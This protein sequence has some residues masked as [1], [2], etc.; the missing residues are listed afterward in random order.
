MARPIRPTTTR[1]RGS[2]GQFGSSRGWFTSSTLYEGIGQFRIKN[3]R[4]MEDIAQEFARDLVAYAQLNA[5]WN[6]RTGDARAGLSTEVEVAIRDEILVS[7]FHTVDYGIWL[8][9]RWG[10]K[11]AII[12]PTIEAMGPRLL[13]RMQH[14]MDRIIYY[15]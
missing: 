13:L 10:G 11:Y 1:I 6:D 4:K 8:E 12:D 15:G 14:M 7:L 9:V 3:L 5:P 2:G